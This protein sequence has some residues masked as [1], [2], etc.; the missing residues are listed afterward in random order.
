M[1]L[2]GQCTPAD[3]TENEKI[4]RKLRPKTGYRPVEVL[5]VVDVD[6]Q[7]STVTILAHDV[8][9]NK[10]EFKIPWTNEDVT[11]PYCP[12]TLP[13]RSAHPTAALPAK[14]TG[15]I[16]HIEDNYCKT[17]RI[18][19]GTPKWPSGLGGSFP[20]EVLTVFPLS[21]VL[22]AVEAAP[23]DQVKVGTV[24]LMNRLL[25]PAQP[26]SVGAGPMSVR[27]TEDGFGAF[28]VIFPA[29][30]HLRGA[31]STIEAQK[32]AEAI[33]GAWS[34]VAT[35]K[36]LLAAGKWDHDRGERA[37]WPDEKEARALIARV[38][39]E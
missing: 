30:R 8:D 5:R 3:L 28:G 9:G 29:R 23:N 32:D 33:A 35:S 16:L 12:S 34:I 4:S 6:A 14:D 24:D 1:G 18:L 2:P 38:L 11:W 39:K 7:T 20:D 21:L 37:I 10:R 26:I 27:L 22:T 17:N 25:A 36:S 13:S 31:I 19:G 15:G